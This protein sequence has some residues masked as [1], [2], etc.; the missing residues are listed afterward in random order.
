ML[1]QTLDRY[2][3][4]RRSSYSLLNNE[5]WLTHCY[6]TNQKS[7]SEI[8]KLVNCSYFAVRCAFK[9]HHIAFRTRKEGIHASWENGRQTRSKFKELN[10]RDWLIQKHHKENLTPRQI[11]KL[12]HCDFTTVMCALKRHNIEIRNTQTQSDPRLKNAK[13]LR[14]MYIQKKLSS[15][16]IGRLTQTWSAVVQSQLHKHNIPIRLPALAIKIAKSKTKKPK[17]QSDDL[18]NMSRDKI[19]TLIGKRIQSYFGIGVLVILKDKDW[20]IQLRLVCQEKGCHRWCIVYLRPG[21]AGPDH[22]ACD[23]NGKYRANLRDE[24]FFCKRHRHE[25]RVI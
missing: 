25:S 2:S 6:V 11:S 8:A 22:Y 13:W 3:S 18:L 15:H 9:R 17:Y 14:R 20:A 10:D 4:L 23:I 16:A 7:L 1:Q 5:Q 12:L 21:C 19:H 24:V